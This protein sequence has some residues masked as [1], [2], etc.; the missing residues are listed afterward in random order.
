[1][2]TATNKELQ[3]ESSDTDEDDHGKAARSTAGQNNQFQSC[4]VDE[5]SEASKECNL[6]A[7]QTV[8]KR[9]IQATIGGQQ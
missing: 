6:Q 4:V 2:F 3:Q 7:I 8:P 5:G 9:R 1:M